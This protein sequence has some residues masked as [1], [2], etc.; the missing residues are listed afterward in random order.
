[1]AQFHELAPEQQGKIKGEH[2][3]FDS[4]APGRQ[5]AVIKD[6]LKKD[7]R[8]AKAQSAKD[9]AAKAN[10]SAKGTLE[11]DANSRDFHKS[12]YRGLVALD[13]AANDHPNQAAMQ[14]VFDHLESARSSLREH[15]NANEA[16]DYETAAGH[17]AHAATHIENAARAFNIISP[18]PGLEP[19]RI[20]AHVKAVADGYKFGIANGKA[21]K[22]TQA[23]PDLSLGKM[24]N[25][26][27]KKQQEADVAAAKYWRN[28]NK[29]KGKPF[30]RQTSEE[31]DSTRQASLSNTRELRQAGAF[32]TPDVAEPKLNA[33]VAQ[34]VA[35]AY[36]TGV[37]KHIGTLAKFGRNSRVEVPLE[38]RD[39][40]FEH[41]KIARSAIAYGRPVPKDT[42]SALGK[43]GLDATRRMIDDE[44]ATRNTSTVDDGSSR[45]RGGRGGSLE[46]FSTG[47]A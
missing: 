16:Q 45:P 9:E 30:I 44:R 40:Y 7:N 29:K 24:A 46:E 20:S 32:S 11:I 47:K 14:P 34:Y 4:Y 43:R 3:E 8:N 1:M 10:S 6:R 26:G 31:V 36:T 35:P 28:V 21:A 27:L 17:I 18:T 2:P 13:S 37:Q 33:P 38:N 22:V 25:A 19:S 15:Y 42:A 39:A 12:L 5:A 41:A 23:K